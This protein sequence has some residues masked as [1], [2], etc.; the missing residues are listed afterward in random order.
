MV[1]AG[2]TLIA[3]QN[4]IRPH[5]VVQIALDARGQVSLAEAYGE[6]GETPAEGKGA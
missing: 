2:D 3:T 4:G 1:R 6:H 5:R